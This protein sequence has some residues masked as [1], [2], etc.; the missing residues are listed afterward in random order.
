MFCLSGLGKREIGTK[1]GHRQGKWNGNVEKSRKSSIQKQDK[2]DIVFLKKA[3]VFLK[4]WY[5]D[6]K[7]KESQTSEIIFMIC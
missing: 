5:N 7:I 4:K 2:M 3:C 1:N 6:I